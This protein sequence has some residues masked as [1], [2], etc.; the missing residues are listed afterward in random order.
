MSDT[1]LYAA[2]GRVCPAAGITE[3][4]WHD[5][6]HTSASHL[7]MAGVGSRVTFPF[8][9]SVGKV[10]RLGGGLPVKFEVQPPVIPGLLNGLWLGE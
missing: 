9:P 8:G 5:L 7:V 3:F 2:F 4:R 6:R 1:T 10:V